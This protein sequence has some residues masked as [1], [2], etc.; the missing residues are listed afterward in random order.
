MASITG[1]GRVAVLRVEFHTMADARGTLNMHYER[2]RD[3]L[4]LRCEL[5]VY[6][7]AHPDHALIREVRQAWYT[8][9]R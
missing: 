8:R 4:R 7:A 9:S 1:S 3:V 6:D 2:I 5:K